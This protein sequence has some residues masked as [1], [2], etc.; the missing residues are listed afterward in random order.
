MKLFVKFGDKILSGLILFWVLWQ[1]ALGLSALKNEPE[2]VSQ[3]KNAEA[4]ALNANPA[5]QVPAVESKLSA[6]IAQNRRW[7]FAFELTRPSVNYM[8]QKVDVTVLQKEYESK[9]TAHVCEMVESPVG[10]GTQVC[11]FPGCAKIVAQKEVY[12]GT[13]RDL[14]C[15]EVSVMTAE[16]TWKG[17]SELRDVTPSYCLVQRRLTNYGNDSPW[18]TVLDETGARKK[19]IG[20]FPHETLAESEQPANALPSGFQLP[21]GVIAITPKDETV[22][23]GPQ[24]DESTKVFRF[25]DY[26]LEPKTSYSYR[27]KAVGLSVRDASEVE[28]VNWTE[29]LIVETK[30][31]QGVGFVRFIPGLRD[32]EGQLRKKSDGSFISPDKAYVRITKL[33]NPPWSPI[34]YFIHYEHR[35]V[36]PGEENLASLGKKVHN[37]PI[38]TSDGSPVYIDAKKE[39]FLHVS[40]TLSLDALTKQ[41]ES[42]KDNWKPYYM[43]VDFTT[44]WKALKVEEDVVEDKLVKS[45][46]NSKGEVENKEE[47]IKKY[48]YFLVVENLETHSKMRLE[49]E[50]DDLTKR[51]LSY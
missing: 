26:N 31:D 11:I 13:P 38:T 20:K 30:E 51:L 7:D 10:D 29:P 22:V 16:L 14:A 12:I 32:K 47:I 3:V 39:N 4:L 25:L 21:V 41:V 44:D 23:K 33:F 9:K 42:E 36:V 50:R 37:Y 17:V 48:R 19:V 6:A 1:M 2:I 8:A 43:E 18:I 46:Y 27:V 5:P 35:N 24:E 15:E 49:L 45:K 40:E 28:S 34:R